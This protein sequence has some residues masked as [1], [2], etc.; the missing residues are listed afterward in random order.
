LSSFHNSIKELDLLDIFTM[1]QLSE[2]DE[3][4]AG[5]QK[6][7]SRLPLKMTSSARQRSALQSLSV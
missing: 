3:A 6:Q 5:K 4:K 2:E 1:I 7:I